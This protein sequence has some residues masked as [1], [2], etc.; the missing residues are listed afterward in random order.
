MLDSGLEPSYNLSKNLFI[1]AM[2]TE[3]DSRHGKGFNPPAKVPVLS[4]HGFFLQKSVVNLS[5]FVSGTGS[6]N[7]TWNR[8][9][10]WASS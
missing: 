1:T 10:P 6:P 7:T 8:K 4:D 3:I 5:R 2:D 9:N